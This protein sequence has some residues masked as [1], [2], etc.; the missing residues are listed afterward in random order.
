MQH[1]GELDITLAG[2]PLHLKYRAYGL[3]QCK[4][5]CGMTATE[6]LLHIYKQ[7]VYGISLDLAIPLIAI[8][9][10]ADPR[11]RLDEADTLIAK[12][13][14]LI[15]KEAD[16]HE[17]NYIEALMPVISKVLETFAVSVHGPKLI[18]AA[19]EETAAESPLPAAVVAVEEVKEVLPPSA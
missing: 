18:E 13:A 16:K 12:I 5:F 2:V 14:E 1:R 6:L 10:I 7:P 4:K 8:G 9:L 15:D 3:S 17:G 19:K 11:Y